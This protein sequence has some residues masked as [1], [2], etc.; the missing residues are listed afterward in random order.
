MSD[1]WGAFADSIKTPL[2]AIAVVAAERLS[3]TPGRVITLAPGEAVAHDNCC[4]GQVWVRLST[5]TANQ[6]NDATRQGGLSV[7]NVPHFLAVVELGVQ[8]CAAVLDSQGKAPTP[9]AIAKDGRQSIDDMAALLSVLR[10][11]DNV[12]SLGT[13]QPSGPEGGCHG[14]SWTFTMRFDNC[15]VCDG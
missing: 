2:E 4:D 9:E 8:R 6:G 1:S 7:C 12:R 15:L 11:D 10:C 3:P 5:L 13:W 14:G